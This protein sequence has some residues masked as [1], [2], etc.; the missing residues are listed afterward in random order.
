MS[1]HPGHIQAQRS[2]PA[3]AAAEAGQVL[4]LLFTDSMDSALEVALHIVWCQR[5]QQLDVKLE[6]LRDV[7]RQLPTAAAA[8]PSSLTYV[9]V[10]E[11]TQTLD[12]AISASLE[13]IST[14]LSI[15]LPQHQQE[16]C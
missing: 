9:H 12:S 5:R 1:R 10:K 16:Y 14:F 8:G 13:L 7:L 2:S 11:A 6:L 15:G 3:S 4:Q